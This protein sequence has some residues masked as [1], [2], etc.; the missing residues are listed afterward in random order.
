[1]KGKTRACN[2]SAPAGIVLA[3]GKST[4]LGQDKADIIYSGATLLGRAVE[5]LRRHCDTVCVVGR[6]PALQHPE[7]ND[8]TEYSNVS[9][10]LDLVPGRGPAG[11]IATALQTLQ[12]P[13]LVLS[14]DLPLMDDATLRR[15]LQG[16][17]ERPDHSL[18][19][20]FRQVETGY[21]EA[22]AAVYEFEALPRFKAAFSNEFYQLN[23][24]LPEPIR[25]HLPY[26]R[27]ESIPF[28]NVNHPSDLSLLRTLEFSRME[29]KSSPQ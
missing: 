6:K 4:R 20:T 18:M 19:T 29:I 17:A 23:R 8:R 26:R 25:H 7:N 11:G 10:L 9:W 3:G 22:L 5:L 2:A 14:C 16:R 27:E 21:I 15:L 28:F 13:C 12:R 24:I 1:M